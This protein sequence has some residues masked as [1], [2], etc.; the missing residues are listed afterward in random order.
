[1]R[2]QQAL[3]CTE[4]IINLKDC[5]AKIFAAI[6]QRDLSAAV[7]IIRQVHSIELKAAKV[8]LVALGDNRRNMISSICYVILQVSEDFDIIMEKEKEVKQLV[9]K[10]FGE[11]IAASNIK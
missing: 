6:E 5:K 3:A 9:Q 2:S 10:D 7:S 4:D 1:M 8:L 11:A